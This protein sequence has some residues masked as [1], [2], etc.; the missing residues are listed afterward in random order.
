M[1]MAWHYSDIFSVSVSIHYIVTTYG[2]RVLAKK[3]T[4]SGRHTT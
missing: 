2:R 1:S 4:Y 3:Q